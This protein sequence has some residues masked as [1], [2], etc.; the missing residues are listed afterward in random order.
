[1]HFRNLIPLF[2]MLLA[3]CDSNE[4]IDPEVLTTD[5]LEIGKTSFVIQ[6]QITEAGSVRPIRYGFLWDTVGGLNIQTATHTIDLGTTDQKKLY[7]VKLEDLTAGTNY[8]VKAFTANLNYTRIYYGNEIT[9]TTL[10]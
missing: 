10:P 7:S 4:A 6:A 1:M 9:V 5:P 8:Y 2:L 3:A